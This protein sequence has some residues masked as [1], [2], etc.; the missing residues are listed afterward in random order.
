MNRAGVFQKEIEKMLNER[1]KETEIEQIKK[2]LLA[3]DVE[4][5]NVLFKHSLL[6]VEEYEAITEKT[7]SHP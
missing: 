3:G 1:Q 7:K 5:A 4:A 6:T 2:A